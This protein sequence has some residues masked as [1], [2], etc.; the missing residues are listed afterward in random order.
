MRKFLLTLFLASLLSTSAFASW[1]NVDI[2]PVNMASAIDDALFDDFAEIFPTSDADVFEIQYRTGTDRETTAGDIYNLT[3]TRSTDTYG[4]RTLLFE[5]PNAALDATNPTSG[6]IGNTLY[7]LV[8]CKDTGNTD[9]IDYLYSRAVSGAINSWTLVTTY[10]PANTANGWG[11]LVATSDANTYWYPISQNT[12]GVPI[13][14]F[15][16]TD[17]GT[18]WAV[19]STMVASPS[20]WSEATCAYAQGYGHICIVRNDNGDYVN[21]IVSTDGLGTTWTAPTDTNLGMAT[22]VKLSTLFYDSTSESLVLIFTDRGD[23]KMYISVTK[24]YKAF[25][26]TW[27]S[28]RTLT[29]GVSNEATVYE[30]D[31]ANRIFLLLTGVAAGTGGGR[32]NDLTYQGLRQFIKF[33]QIGP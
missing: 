26:G 2:T 1:T 28:P 30:V 8:N 16:T 19:G 15:K 14:Q 33:G 11:R 18:T 7:M 20:N 29:P 5:C 13:T 31:T 3:Y 27:E 21:Q 9:S 23:T 10:D 4:S 25:Q 6:R 17:G 22:G 24:A 32:L 12:P